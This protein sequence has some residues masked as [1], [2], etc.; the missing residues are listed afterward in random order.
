M[1]VYTK[2]EQDQLID[3]LGEYAH[4]TLVSFE[5]ISDGIENT[6]YF[7]TTSEEQYVLTLF[8]VISEQELPYFLNL[9]AYLAENEVP[10]AHPVADIHGQYIR[11][12]NGKPAAL[13]KR[14]QGASTTDPTIEQCQAV[15]C[16]LARLHDIGQSYPDHREN[17]RGPHWWK[18]TVEKLNPFLAEE[19]NE[20]LQKEIKYQLSY[21][22][23][24]LPRGVIHADLFRDNALF[25]GNTLTGMIDFYYACNDVL[26]YDVAVTIND[27][28]ALPDGSIDADRGDA[29]LAAYSKRRPITIHEKDAWQVMLRAGA[30]RFW[31]SRLQ[32]LHF[33]REGEITHTKDPEVFKNILTQHIAQ[34]HK[35][36]L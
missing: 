27:W 8:E 26:L 32:D 36:K 2:I 22:H 19:D 21:R 1:S 31:L 16:M 15:G 18:E 34:K 33:P 24:S 9:M 25:V 23:A 30:L 17:T 4:G 7:V 35:W 13:V 10:S 14:L 20:L 28:C 5:G 6:N 3:F 11:V 29:L 12:L